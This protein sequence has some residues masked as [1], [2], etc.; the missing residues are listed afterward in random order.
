[1]D[2]TELC[3]GELFAVGLEI[4]F[5]DDGVVCFLDFAGPRCWLAVEERKIERETLSKFDMAIADW[6]VLA[7][8]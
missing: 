7:V 6:S 8:A 3:F 2:E 5:M 1:M 4:T